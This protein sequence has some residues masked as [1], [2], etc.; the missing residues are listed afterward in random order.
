MVL[1]WYLP[2]SH[3]AVV[4]TT[5][6][7]VPWN[8]HMISIYIDGLVQDCSNSSVLAMELLQSCSS[9]LYDNLGIGEHYLYQGCY[10]VESD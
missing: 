9:H 7:Y 8:M 10:I 6:Q 4:N 3:N 2:I 5:V 1:T